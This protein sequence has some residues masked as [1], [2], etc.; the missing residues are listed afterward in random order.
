MFGVRSPVEMSRDLNFPD[1]VPELSGEQVRLRE[2]FLRAIP[3][4][5][6]ADADACFVY[7]LRAPRRSAG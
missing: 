3:A 1:T 5:G 6:V 4:E 2:L 7:A